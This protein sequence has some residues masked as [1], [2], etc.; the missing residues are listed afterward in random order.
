MADFPHNISGA[1]MARLVRFFLSTLALA[2]GLAHAQGFSSSASSFGFGAKCGTIDPTGVITGS[3]YGEDAKRRLEQEF[4]AREDDLRLRAKTLRRLEYLKDV[5]TDE[6][7]NA[8]LQ[9]VQKELAQIEPGFQEDSQKFRKDLEKRRAEELQVAIK[10]ITA[11]YEKLAAEQGY[12]RLYQTSE[13]API[14]SAAGAG[15]RPCEGVNN[16]TADVIRILDQTAT[17]PRK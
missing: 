7:D 16:I 3:R 6:K 5:A 11:A 14:F 8:K 15:D 4:K 13:K 12:E 17:D 1:G 9:S 2:A 10:A